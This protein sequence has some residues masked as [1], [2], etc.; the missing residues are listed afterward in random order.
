MLQLK[1]EKCGVDYEKPT[2]FKKWND[3]NPN[4]FFKWS[5]TF[6]DTCR[7]TKECQA[8]KKLPDVLKLLTNAKNDDISTI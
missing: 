6:C 7:R 5:L 8:L 3:K 1:C 4:V 2:N